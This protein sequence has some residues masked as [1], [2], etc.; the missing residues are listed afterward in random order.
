MLLFIIFIQYIFL[1]D[2]IASFIHL[3]AML[4]TVFIIYD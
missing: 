1:F 4:Y 3:D 2:Y